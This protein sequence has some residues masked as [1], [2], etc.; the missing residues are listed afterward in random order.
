MLIA[1]LMGIVLGGLVLGALA[2]RVSGFWPRATPAPLPNTGPV[3]E[4]DPE[5]GRP[6]MLITVS[7]SGWAPAERIT[8]RLAPPGELPTPP[9]SVGTVTAQYDGTFQTGFSVPIV[10]PWSEFAEVRVEAEGDSSR[11]LAATVF[12]MRPRSVIDVPTATPTPEP[13]TA[14]PTPEITETATPTAPAATVQP[15]AEP[16][17]ATPEP[18]GWRGEYFNTPILS[19]NP[20]LVR[21]D[22]VLDFDWARGSPAPG[23]VADGFSARWTRTLFFEAGTYRFY[24]TAD[25]GV[26]VW[27]NGELIIDEWHLARSVTYTADRTLQSGNHTLVVEY[28]EAW[29]DARVR[30]WWDRP[31]DFP[32]WRGEYFDTVELKG[33]PVLTRNDSA[34]NFDWGTGSPA[35]GVPADRFSVRWTRTLNFDAGIYRFRAL[36][37]DG[38]RVYVGG[39]LVI[40]EWTNG[41]AREVAGDIALAAGPHTVRVEYYEAAGDAVMQLT[42][43]LRDAY[44]DWKAEYWGNRTLSGL[45]VLV[46]NDKS[47]DFDW[48][49]EAPAPQLPADGFSARWTRTM[50]FAAG[51]YRFSVIVDDGARLWIDDRLVID[52]WQDGEAREVTADVLLTAGA[53]SL[54]LE[55][56]E[57]TGRARIRLHWEAVTPTFS[58]W[59]GE[60]WS[61]ATL[62]GAPTLVRNDRQIDFDWGRGA[63]ATGMPVDNFSARWTRTVNLNEGIYRFSARADDGVRI[64]INGRL[65]L[66]EWHTSSGE[67]VYTRDLPLA[68]G[69]HTIVVEYFE[70]GG[71]ALIKVG[72]ERL[73]G[74]A[75]ATPPPT[76]T[77]EPTVPPTMTPTIVPTEVPTEVATEVP[78][79]VPTQAPTE[80]P[81]PTLVPTLDLSLIVTATPTATLTLTPPPT[82]AATATTR[83]G[84]SWVW[85]NEIMPLPGEVDW[86]KDG[87][88]DAG[89][90]WLEFYNPG[91]RAI[92]ISHWILEVGSNDDATLD[93]A[94]SEI[95]A[96]QLPEGTVVRPGGYLVIYSQDS[97]LDLTRGIRLLEGEELR[98]EVGEEQ[99]LILAEMEPDQ[100]LS[101]DITG[102]W[103]EGWRPTPGRVNT[104]PIDTKPVLEIDG[105]FQRLLKRL[106]KER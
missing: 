93:E 90:A 9:I 46:R 31:S 21:Y 8:L 65:M 23:V 10:S 58:D 62:S 29:G 104:P 106:G 54:R 95:Q 69:E 38:V 68:G 101:R 43:E 61:N 17:T 14:T 100:A 82:P 24:A 45:P 15:T 63:P 91:R 16:P 44:P 49:T 28:F 80:T 84:N 66:D 3:I 33:S 99:A 59:K 34:I 25:D 6:G 37:D 79:E 92:N 72:Y 60:Y 76:A 7:G 97:G 67:V 11:N 50:N 13:A 86:N 74:L 87:V 57:N 18:D 81:T 41:R 2:L 35:A 88:V 64:L 55:M 51:T 102:A 85:I 53:H 103:H 89:D 20:A 27:L 39:T 98:D 71:N 42:W 96:Y 32:E 56:Y 83:P 75:T 78:T 52:N 36:V 77:P 47:I 26:R 105:W 30:V 19:G 12:D 1:G 5:W 73:G 4:I 70:G 94:S 22:P 48:G 40:D